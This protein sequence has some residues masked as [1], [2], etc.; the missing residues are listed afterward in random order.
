MSHTDIEQV[1]SLAVCAC[2]VR[3]TAA[4]RQ[5]R[6]ASVEIGTPERLGAFAEIRRL[7]TS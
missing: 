4:V 1:I 2:L 3:C 6:P 5:A 7:S